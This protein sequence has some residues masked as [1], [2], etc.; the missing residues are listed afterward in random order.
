M[1]GFGET[2][3]SLA[4]VLIKQATPDI[5]RL[6][7]FRVTGLSVQA[8]PRDIT[9]EVKLL[10]MKMKLEGVASTKSE[11]LPFETPPDPDT[12]RTAAH[13]LQD[14]EQRFLHEIF[15]IWPDS[16]R[17]DEIL[18]SP[19]SPRLPLDGL[20]TV[21]MH[22]RAVASAVRAIDLEFADANCAPLS[23]PEHQR[24]WELWKES[25]GA[26][27]AVLQ[28]EAFWK[29]LA[30]RAHD[31]DDPRLNSATLSELRNALPRSLAKIHAI[32]AFRSGERQGQ[33]ITAQHAAWARRLA[34]SDGDEIL[35][36][37]SKTLR[38]RVGAICS[39]MGATAESP[40]SDAPASIRALLSSVT[41]LLRIAAAAL[42]ADSVVS[43][44]LYD[45]AAEAAH[46][47]LV[48][49]CNSTKDFAGTAELLEE[50]RPL[51]RSG[52][53]TERILGDLQTARNGSW[54]V[55]YIDPLAENIAE[56]VSAD[57]QAAEKLKR[58]KAE[59]LPLFN[60]L[61]GDRGED[62]PT[63][64]ASRMIAS[65]LRSIS[66]HLHN[67]EGKYQLALDAINLAITVCRDETLTE[68]LESDKRLVEQRVVEHQIVKDL[69]PID[70]APSLHTTN[71]WGTM[72]YGSSD[73]E[74]RTGSYLTTRYFTA[75]F[76]PLCPLSRYR[77]RTVGDGRYEFL[78]RAPLRNLD[79]IH[80]G[81]F[82]AAI[83]ILLAA[84]A[85]NT[86]NA[87]APAVT[88]APATQTFDPPQ[89]PVAFPAAHGSQSR[90]GAEVGGGGNVTAASQPKTSDYPPSDASTGLSETEELK[91]EIDEGRPR[92]SQM[93]LDLESIQ[94]ELASM[95]SKL[96][97]ISSDIDSMESQM[98]LGIDVDEASYRD[99]IRE[100][101]ELVRRYNGLLAEDRKK[102]EE[103]DAFVRDFNEKVRQYN[104]AIATH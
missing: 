103:Y 3:T 28:D 73:P 74:K 97:S 70:R 21:A 32:Q 100:H 57:L 80:I 17:V 53:V 92:L 25:A 68:T 31:L 63:P 84:L 88:D 16:R 42:G 62:E 8:S 71:G 85:S 35:L 67:D 61:L 55:L 56:I 29:L 48:T 15:W 13:T 23:E 66:I 54:D 41:P 86:T 30:S 38:D 60:K 99:S 58:F 87:T 65:E 91:K 14:T 2:P 96:E 90:H 101:N 24:L 37:A 46:R 44:N 78:G 45:T 52:S 39:Q 51:A 40:P 94:D 72:L 11:E 89:N 22:N 20:S 64:M 9:R 81:A 27:R 33:G 18:K 77:V 59:I 34:P 104:L 49:Y 69:E 19:R 75:F 95:N 82:V 102:A 10:Q 5:F 36:E 79:R 76:I 6:N 7:A 83:I 98:R 1:N 47:S 43:R 26:W 93:K 4:G 50:V 12:I